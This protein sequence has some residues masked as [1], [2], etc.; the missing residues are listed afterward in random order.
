M[1]VNKSLN[2]VFLA[3]MCLITVAFV[4][5]D[6]C[7]MSTNAMDRTTVTCNT[8]LVGNPASLK[9]EFDLCRDE[10]KVSAQID[11]DSLRIHLRREGDASIDIPLSRIGSLQLSITSNSYDDQYIKVVFKP[12]G[13]LPVTLY[14]KRLSEQ[15]TGCTA[16]AYWINSQSIGVFVGI[17]LAALVLLVSCCCCCCWC[18]GCCCCRKKQ[19]IQTTVILNA[20]QAVRPTASNIP[21]MNM[22][23]DK[24]LEN[25]VV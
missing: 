1:A 21:Y 6:D 14:R 12:F 19:P 2:I 9:M 24:E 11:V 23:D 7:Y 8:D 22:K 15:D 16:I 13:I 10:P 20:G 4:D 5:A 25:R 18:C 17:G 3:I